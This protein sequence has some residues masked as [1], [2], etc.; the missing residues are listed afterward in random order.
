MNVYRT[1]MDKGPAERYDGN[2]VYCRLLVAS[3]DDRK[4]L[5]SAF[6]G[7]SISISSW[8]P[9]KAIRM[10]SESENLAKPL[11][12]RAAIDA[13]SDPMVLSRR[14]LDVLL[15]HIGSL[16]QVLPLA[17]DEAEYFLFN[18]TNV[19]DA[20]DIAAS[21]V[22]Y[23]KDGGFYRVKR[24]AFKP[25][26]VRDQWLFKIPQHATGFAFVTDRFVE[27]VQRAGLTGFG[28]EPLWS[29]EAP[30]DARAA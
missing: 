2:D 10:Y 13:L 20:L 19:I 4:V 28:F 6:R 5:D 17:F 25:D 1:T 29:D 8:R 3:D 22:V 18:I 15:P 11:G 30:S 27:V 26:V 12:D 14:A 24:Y 16:G 21:D 23:F 7:V 9:L